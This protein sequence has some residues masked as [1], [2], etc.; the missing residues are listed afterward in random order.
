MLNCIHIHKYNERIIKTGSVRRFEFG[1]FMPARKIIYE[2]P[3][4]HFFGS[5]VLFDLMAREAFCN[6]VDLEDQ[7]EID[8]TFS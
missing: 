7:Q 2:K 1:N 4:R 3:L 6:S 8:R 5:F